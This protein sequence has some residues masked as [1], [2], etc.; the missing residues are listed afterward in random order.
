MIF[1]KVFRLNRLNAHIW[2][3]T[4]KCA[5]ND[6]DQ[7]CDENSSDFHKMFKNSYCVYHFDL[8]QQF[9]GNLA[10]V[11]IAFCN[12]DHDIVDCL[13]SEKKN[14]ISSFPQW[15]FNVTYRPE[16]R[17]LDLMT[18][19]HIDNI[20]VILRNGTKSS[21]EIMIECNDYIMKH[22]G[23]DNYSKTMCAIEYA[24]KE[25]T[26]IF[27]NIIFTV[28]T[29]KIISELFD[30]CNRRNKSSKSKKTTYWRPSSSSK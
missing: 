2:K 6:C 29:I 15:Y 12:Q 25:S 28:D 19:S 11:M 26:A 10:F 14:I 18:K 9:D 3:M 16:Q 4:K 7:L 5:M 30:T 21:T 20:N 8:L 23:L 17:V 1:Y 22:F 24:N 13:I 27:G